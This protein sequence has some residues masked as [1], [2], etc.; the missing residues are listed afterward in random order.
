MAKALPSYPMSGTCLGFGVIIINSFDE[1]PENKRTNTDV[2]RESFH[3]LFT[4]IGL[5]TILLDNLKKNVLL[6]ELRKISKDDKLKEH[7]MFA[8]AIR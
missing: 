5:Q 2:E 1:F 3:K 4:A 7:S 8:L 6:A